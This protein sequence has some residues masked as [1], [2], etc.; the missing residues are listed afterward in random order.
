[1]TELQILTAVRNNKGPI[2]YATL[3]GLNLAEPTPDSVS[4]KALITSLIEQK[5][6]TGRTAAYSTISITEKGRL[7]LNHLNDIEKL[8]Q[9]QEKLRQE[10]RKHGWYIA[11]FT[12]ICSALLSEPLWY[13]IHW[14]LDFIKVAFS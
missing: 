6:L 12:S 7:R 1:M 10:D 4:D 3:L 9:K 2:S 13:G 11:I 14:L 8:K 5:Y